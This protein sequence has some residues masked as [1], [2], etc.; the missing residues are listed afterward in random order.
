MSNWT[1]SIVPT[2][3]QTIYLVLD[4]FGKRGRAW[5]E[6]DVEATDLETVI[7]DLMSGQYHSPVR[8]VGFNT[9]EGWSRD[10]SEDIAE[11]IQRRLQGNRLPAQLQDFI[12]R[13]EAS[14][15]DRRQPR[16]V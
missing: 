11:E 14:G 10:V 13:H 8:V 9:A 12:A 2:D 6:T 1:P 15:D 4:D 16:L 3:D 7:T 5:R